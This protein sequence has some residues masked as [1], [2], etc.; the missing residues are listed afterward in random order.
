MCRGPSGCA[1]AGECRCQ[2][3]SRQGG[4][5]C[6]AGPSVAAASKLAGVQLPGNESWAA[7]RE[8]RDSWGPGGGVAAAV[9][10]PG[11][12]CPS[13]TYAPLFAGPFPGWRAAT[14][15]SGHPRHRA[16]SGAGC[17][18]GASSQK[19]GRPWYA[20]RAVYGLAGRGYVLDLREVCTVAGCACDA[21]VVPSVLSGKGRRRARRWLK[22]VP[23]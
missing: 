15:L 16:S 20:G 4:C 21:P 12:W 23:P 9:V 10:S 22:P 14:A 1:G 11:V 8:P 17:D 7:L 5:P 13:C 2:Q 18:C 3:V 6:A 19:T